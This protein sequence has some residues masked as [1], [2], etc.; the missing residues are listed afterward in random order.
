MKVIYFSLICLLLTAFNPILA[1]L[2]RRAA[3]DIGSGGQK[4]P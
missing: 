1:E 2:E 3:I 4:L